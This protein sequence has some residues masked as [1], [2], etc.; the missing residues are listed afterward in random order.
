MTGTTHRLFGLRVRASRPIPYAPQVPDD[1]EA[2]DVVITFGALPPIRILDD[3]RDELYP[4]LRAEGGWLFRYPD[5]TDFF[6]DDA[7][8]AIG[9]RWR[10]PLTFEDACTYLVGPV[11]AFVARLRGMACLHAAAV[12]VGE[13]L[14]QAIL[15][16]GAS[17]AGKST[18]AAALVA[19]GA[20]LVAE[21]VTVLGGGLAVPSYAG[22]RLWPDSAALLFGS[23][24]ALP[25]ISPTWDKRMLD[26]VPFADGPLP[27]VAL[28]FLEDRDADSLAPAAAA[29]RLVAHSYRPEQ[30]TAA[31]RRRELE[32]FA[33][34]A[35][36]VP[37]RTLS[38]HTP[39]RLADLVLAC[40]TSSTTAG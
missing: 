13:E 23:R 39:E 7:G 2:A 22:I 34:L 17:G 9:C 24:D 21:D 16:A 30:L 18:L 19:R 28:F 38:R 12:G 29:M 33:A 25:P 36:A 5:G 8:T 15:I 3:P 14:L 6:V 35:A 4:L 27:V 40:T 11:F 1:A 20:T 32:A 37:A 31:M 10:D 26:R